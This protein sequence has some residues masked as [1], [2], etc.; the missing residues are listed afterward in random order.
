MVGKDLEQKAPTV[1]ITTEVIQNGKPRYKQNA[2][3]LLLRK[4]GA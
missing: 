3:E 1:G 2:K 4:G